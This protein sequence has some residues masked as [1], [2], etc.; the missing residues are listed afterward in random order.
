MIVQGFGFKRPPGNPQL[1]KKDQVTILK[2]IGKLHFLKSAN[3][4]LLLN[5]KKSQQTAQQT[6]DIIKKEYHLK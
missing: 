3:S 2:F 4:Y 5:Y 6:L 1:M